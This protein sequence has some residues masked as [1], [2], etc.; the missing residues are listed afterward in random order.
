MA[1]RKKESVSTDNSFDKLCSDLQK[2]GADGARRKGL[3]K[4]W[5]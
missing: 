2:N 3:K 5:G 4:T 1:S